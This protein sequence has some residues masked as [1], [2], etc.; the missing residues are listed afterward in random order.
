LEG[1]LR[2]REP[3]GVLR[4]SGFPNVGPGKPEDLCKN[5]K[6]E[7]FEGTMEGANCQ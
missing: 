1:G 7:A 5:V 4:S 3:S 6:F 2:G